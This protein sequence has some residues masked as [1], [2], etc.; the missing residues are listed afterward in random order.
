MPA[1]NFQKQ[2][3]PAVERGDKNQTIRSSIRGARPGATA[4]LYTGQRTTKCRKLGTG[5]VTGVY[6][7]EIGR[8]GCGEPYA[9]INYGDRLEH[10]VHGDMDALARA[11]G[12]QDKEKMTAWFET[13]KELPY[14][15]FLHQWVRSDLEKAT[16]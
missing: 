10:L 8:T 12:F 14:K 5:T 6:P 15:G 11:D 16:A 9:C 13:Q 2:F 7:I 1:Y 4:Y 3:A